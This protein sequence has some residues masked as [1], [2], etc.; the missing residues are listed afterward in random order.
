MII[1]E[2]SEEESE[3]EEIGSYT[4]Y[5]ITAVENETN[6]TVLRIPDVFTDRHTAEKYAVMFNKESLDIIH[7]RNVID[8]IIQ[9]D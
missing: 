9:L 2:I 8:D 7:L 1:Y 5:G 4:S 6:T 3:N